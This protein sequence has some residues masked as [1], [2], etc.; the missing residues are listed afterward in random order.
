MRNE[1]RSGQGTCDARGHVVRGNNAHLRRAYALEH[2]GELR[3]RHRV[4]ACAVDAVDLLPDAQH[5][6]LR[7]C[8]VVD[9]FDDAPNLRGHTRTTARRR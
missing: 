4:H 1:Y 9:G 7:Q 3:D 2:L 5:A 6:R 8:W